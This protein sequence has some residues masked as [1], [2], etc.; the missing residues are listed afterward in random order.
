[1]KLLYAYD[2]KKE[3]LV[4]TGDGHQVVLLWFEDDDD[5]FVYY[6]DD[7]TSQTFINRIINKF[8]TTAD[9]MFS[10][11]N[12]ERIKSDEQFDKYQKWIETNF[13]YQGLMK[14]EKLDGIG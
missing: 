2:E 8:E 1:M 10:G 5:W 13:N 9:R 7:S 11:L 6:C 12:F 14:D 4:S 3:I